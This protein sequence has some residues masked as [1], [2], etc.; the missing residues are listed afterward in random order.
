MAVLSE[1]LDKNANSI[2]YFEQLSMHGGILL[3]VK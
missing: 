2:T 3:R 1:F